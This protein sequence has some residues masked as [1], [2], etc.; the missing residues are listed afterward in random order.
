MDPTITVALIGAAAALST[1]GLTLW[2]RKKVGEVHAEVKNDHST[3]L[4]TDLDRVLEKLD[5][6][7]DGQARQDD[8]ISDM[9]DD[10]RAERQERIALAA[11]IDR[12]R[13]R[14]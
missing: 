4:R 10:I 5:F 9:R 13:K 14:R 8:E 11:R 6:V 7:I 3:N 2:Q 1:T 12:E